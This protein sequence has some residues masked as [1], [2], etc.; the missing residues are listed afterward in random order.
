MC[1]LWYRPGNPWR[2]KVILAFPHHSVSAGA[3][4]IDPKM[5]E[6]QSNTTLI[7]L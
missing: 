7:I 4:V 5:Y 2:N 1:W 6:S 3:R